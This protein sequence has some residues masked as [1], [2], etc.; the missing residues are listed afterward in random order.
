MKINNK[1]YFGAFSRRYSLYKIECSLG[2]QTKA[3]DSYMHCT[4]TYTLLLSCFNS[5]T[6]YLLC[7]CTI[8][9][10]IMLAIQIQIHKY[11]STSTHKSLALY[12]CECL[13]EK[14]LF[15]PLFRCTPFLMPILYTY[16]YIYRLYASW[17]IHISNSYGFVFSFSFFVCLFDLISPHCCTLFVLSNIEHIAYTK[18]NALTRLNL[19]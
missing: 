12:F 11:T 19:I 16:M 5:F 17:H 10:L 2:A 3:L 6:A 15:F 14:T 1:V 9:L 8:R 13:R 18:T 4:S 7:M